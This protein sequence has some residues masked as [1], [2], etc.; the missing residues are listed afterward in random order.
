M[1]MEGQALTRSDLQARLVDRAWSDPAFLQQ[2]RT[3]PKAALE[4]EL[5]QGNPGFKL[6]DDLNVKLVEEAPDT[7]YV[8]LPTRPPVAAGNELS[9]EDLEAM[10]GGSGLSGFFEIYKFF[11]DQGWQSWGQ[12]SGGGGGGGGWTS[13][14]GPS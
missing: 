14:Q 9:D 1:T 3:N 8:I 2:L 5:G 12:Q 4:T 11:R 13:V 6:P 7:M 10:S